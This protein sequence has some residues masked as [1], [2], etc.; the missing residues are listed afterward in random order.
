MTDQFRDI[1]DYA[2]TAQMEEKLDK[3]E[4]LWVTADGTQTVSDGWNAYVKQ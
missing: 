1:V 3:V 4:A 2:F